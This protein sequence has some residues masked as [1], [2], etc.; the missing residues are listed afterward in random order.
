MEVFLKIILAHLAL[1]TLFT[2]CRTTLPNQSSE[3][4]DIK[5]RPRSS[6]LATNYLTTLVRGRLLNSTKGQGYVYI[7]ICEHSV[8]RQGE[9]KPEC[10]GY[11]DTEETIKKQLDE[12]IKGNNLALEYGE[13]DSFFLEI[14][15]ADHF[16]EQPLEDEDLQKLGQDQD[17]Y[18]SRN[19][20]YTNIVKYLREL[21]W[22]RVNKEGFNEYGKPKYYT[23]YNRPDIFLERVDGDTIQDDISTLKRMADESGLEGKLMSCLNKLSFSSGRKIVENTNSALNEVELKEINYILEVLKTKGLENGF[24]SFYK[25]PAL[26]KI[27]LLRNRV[28][29]ELK[30]Y[31]L[32]KAPKD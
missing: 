14:F 29:N 26:A 12:Y 28:E 32:F 5:V 24:K 20:D 30:Y 21:I 6:D 23:L 11:V 15:K 8:S 25:E 7:K 16:I 22:A 31:Y 18:R 1:L 9:N 10:D 2:G 4:K 27:E 3:N 13:F 19:L 17:Q